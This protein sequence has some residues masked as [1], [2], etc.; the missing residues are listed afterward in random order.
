[1]YINLPQN[2]EK[3]HPL[4]N[5]ATKHT[6]Q[7]PTFDLPSDTNCQP[8]TPLSNHGTKHRR[9][10]LGHRNDGSS[11]CLQRAVVGKCQVTWQKTLVWVFLKNPIEEVISKKKTWKRDVFC[12]RYCLVVCLVA[13]LF[14]CF[15]WKE[16]SL[17]AGG[18][19][20]WVVPLTKRMANS[21]VT[22]AN[23]Q[24]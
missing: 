10:W 11:K 1:M 21:Q 12:F 8:P 19:Y 2:K 4:P 13:C 6:Q 22:S 23:R 16:T 24:T 7:T 9:G 14:V 15:S 3:T 18:Q 17:V 20:S 5:L